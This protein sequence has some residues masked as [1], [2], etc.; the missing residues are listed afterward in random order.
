MRTLSH[1]LGLVLLMA[2]GPVTAFD[3]LTIDATLNPSAQ[4]IN[5]RVTVE[6]SV[7]DSNWEE[8]LFRLYSNFPCDSPST[9]TD[10]PDNKPCGTEIHG[11]TVN[12]ADVRNEAKIEGTDLDVPIPKANHSSGPLE[13]T[14]DFATH[15]SDTG[16]DYGRQAD[17]YF[18]YGWFPMPAPR[19]GNEWLKIQYGPESELVGDC[20][21]ITAIIHVPDSLELVSPGIAHIDSTDGIR[22]Y[23]CNLQESHDFPVCILPKGYESGTRTLD[24]IQLTIRY[25]PEDSVVLDTVAEQIGHTMAFMSE[26]VGPYPFGELVVVIGGPWIRG[27]LE[28]PRLILLER[29]RSRFAPALY[30]SLVVHETIHEWFYGIL[31]SNQALDPWMDE[32]ATE[33]FTERVIRD[34]SGGEGDRFS[35]WGISASFQDMRRLAARSVWTLVP[36]TLRSEQYAEPF[37]YFNAVYDKGCLVVQ[38]L[39]NHL[40]DTDRRRFWHDYYQQF[41]FRSPTPLDFVTLLAQYPPYSSVSHVQHILNSNEPIDYQVEDISIRE[42]SRNDTILSDSAAER[43]SQYTTKVTCVFYHPLPLPVALRVEYLDGTARDTTIVPDPGYH[44][45]S[46]VGSSPG[47]TAILDPYYQI[48]LDVNL[49]NN[50]LSRQGGRGVA[51]RLMSGLTFL[52]QSLFQSVWGF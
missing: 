6:F 25:R 15:I 5:G 27:G 32:A 31:N 42:T 50:S 13:I 47:Q 14:I 8:V 3:K 19:R 45:Y 18:L 9:R 41:S 35:Y 36:V 20:F 38:T 44:T 11:V 12:G 24:H 33:Y 23:T 1:S 10:L 49:L 26:N 16:M 21:D 4:T 34:I 30:R 29:P 51:L 43:V 40:N 48:S 22:A 17:G 28:L 7:P 46:F 52:L 39:V 37:E 2:A